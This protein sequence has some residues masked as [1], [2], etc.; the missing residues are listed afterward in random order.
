MIT[1]GTYQI[2]KSALDA[3]DNINDTERS[4]LVS[5]LRKPI[6]APRPLALLTQKEA[7]QELRCSR[8]TLWRLVKSGQLHPVQIRGLRRFKRKD[9]EILGGGAA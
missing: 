4:A 5:L 7:C 9:V 8:Q 1:K 2:I 6:T 3:D